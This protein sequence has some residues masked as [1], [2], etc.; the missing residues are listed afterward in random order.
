[1][2]DKLTPIF[3]SIVDSRLKQLY[4]QEA[5]Q[6]MAVDEQWLRK[7]LNPKSYSRSSD[8]PKLAPSINPQSVTLP[9]VDSVNPA[10]AKAI[11]TQGTEENIIQ[12]KGV[13][14]VE[15]LLIGLVLKNKASWDQFWK[16]NALQ[17]IEHSGTKTLLEKA[18]AICGQHPEKFDKLAGLLIS[19]VDLPELVLAEVHSGAGQQVATNADGN[20]FAPEEREAKLLS[21]C[22]KRLQDQFLKAQ[23]DQ[24]TQEMK[25][26]PSPE[27]LEQFMNIQRDRMALSKGQ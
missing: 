7:A 2:A 26:N 14:K 13:S 9:V 4:M 1:L 21:D 15:G 11:P 22:L 20:G 23:A 3:E 12:L 19:F 18:A 27:K 5:A 24:L 25:S 6:K 17:W 10:H 8:G 16:L